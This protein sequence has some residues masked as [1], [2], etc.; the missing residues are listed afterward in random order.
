MRKIGIGTAI[1]VSILLTMPLTGILYLGKVAFGL[2]F[3]AEDLYGWFVRAGVGPFIDLH[4]WL[5]SRGAADGR[6]PT[7]AADWASLI[8]SV[9]FLFIITIL[10][11]VFFHLLAGRKTFALDWADGVAIGALLGAPLIFASLN[12]G[13]SLVNPIVQ[14]IWLAVL[15]VGWGVALAL[16]YRRLGN[17]EAAPPD[18]IDVPAL[19][20]ESAVDGEV[21]AAEALPETMPTAPEVKES[22]IGRRQ[23]LLRLGASTAAITT[24]S[25]VAA[26][27]LSSP[28]RTA[29]QRRT[30]PAADPETVEFYNNM[31]RRF[32]I[33][34]LQPGA[35]AG[36]VNVL[37][38][39]VEYPDHH[40]VSVW[41]GEQSPIVVYE[42]I[43][44][45]L[46][47]YRDSAGDS[48]SIVDI[49]WLDR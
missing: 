36:E 43:E 18:L 48:E 2:P 26:A 42:N 25:G 33:A 29:A 28:E 32:S 47:A 1:L 46:A 21:T 6:T 10:V 24:I 16:V 19:E 7:Q 49:I 38:L 41:I 23:F 31:F 22:A 34:R 37:A 27:A 15:F 39:G 12:G 40:Y 9:F 20:S 30:L 5:A 44:T 3:V 8:L 13:F 4:N 17:S 14:A 35:A 11:G 45:A